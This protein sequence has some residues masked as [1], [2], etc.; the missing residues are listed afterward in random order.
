[1]ARVAWRIDAVKA[2]DTVKVAMIGGWRCPSAVKLAAAARWSGPVGG[3]N[4]PST[5]EPA[6]P[7]GRCGQMDGAA[8]PNFLVADR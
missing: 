2:L 1:M 7:S 6:N 8:N 5:V 3:T 4:P